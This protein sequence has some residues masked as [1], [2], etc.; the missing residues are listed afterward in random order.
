METNPY[1]T[2]QFGNRDW[3]ILS[4]WLTEDSG[5]RLPTSYGA[6]PQMSRDFLLE[7]NKARMEKYRPTRRKKIAAWVAVFFG[8]LGLL[9]GFTPPPEGASVLQNIIAGILLAGVF[10]IPGVY[11][12][13]CNRRD[14]ET[15]V[16]WMRAD[17]SYRQQLA[18]VTEDDRRM[19][20]EPEEWPHIPRRHWAFV[21]IIVAICFFTFGVTVPSTNTPA[22]PP[23]VTHSK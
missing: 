20:A 13:L 19:L 22:P 5:R 4:P 2:N 9:G 23:S 16:A 1:S 10:L 21:W 12:L 3:D 8:G 7:E 11:W 17:A 14:K 6:S 18:F 15:I